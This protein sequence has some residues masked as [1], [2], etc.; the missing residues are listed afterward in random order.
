MATGPAGRPFD[1]DTRI[2]EIL[3]RCEPG[4]EAHNAISEARR[5]LRDASDLPVC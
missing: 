4:S 2:D 1:F 3:V 5:Y